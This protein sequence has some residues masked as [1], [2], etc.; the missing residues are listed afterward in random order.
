MTTIG[1]F[2]IYSHRFIHDIVTSTLNASGFPDGLYNEKELLSENVKSKE[3][4][5]RFLNEL[6]SLVGI[7]EGQ[8]VDV[9]AAKIVAGLEPIK[10]NHLLC[11]FGSIALDD[12][13]DRKLAI[14]RCLSGENPGDAPRPLHSLKKST[15][16]PENMESSVNGAL[17]DIGHCAGGGEINPDKYVC[18][19][20]ALSGLS[21]EA[22]LQLCDS[23][24]DTIRSWTKELGIKRPKCTDKLLNRPPFRF[25]HDLVMAVAF[26]TGFALDIFWYVHLVKQHLDKYGH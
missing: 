5:I 20:S 16:D 14:Q 1:I 13:I 17:Q 22:K 15:N 6:I 8:N 18:R 19:L 4:K 7:C 9:S 10:T 12:D 26:E 24:Q 11:K 23:S 21:M 3:S 25:L 2:Y